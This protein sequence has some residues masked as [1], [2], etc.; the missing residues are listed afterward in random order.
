[1]I[2]TSNEN[3]WSLQYYLMKVIK[4]SS[5]P[6]AGVNLPLE[7]L[8]KVAPE[9]VSLA[10]IMVSVIPIFLLYPIILKTLT[11]GVVVGSLKG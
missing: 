4:E 3:L 5:M 7:L 8:Q 1:M 9:T 6:S 10:A 2:Y 11:K